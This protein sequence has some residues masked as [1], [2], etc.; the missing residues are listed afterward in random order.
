MSGRAQVSAMP[1]HPSP[2]LR[3]D[4]SFPARADSTS[5]MCNWLSIPPPQCRLLARRDAEDDAKSRNVRSTRSLLL[6]PE[7]WQETG[8]GSTAAWLHRHPYIGASQTG[9]SIERQFSSISLLTLGHSLGA[10]PAPCGTARLCFGF[11]ALRVS[12]FRKSL[13]NER[14]RFSEPSEKAPLGLGSGAHS[15]RC[16][17]ECPEGNPGKYNQGEKQWH[18][19]KARS[20]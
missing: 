13:C 4:G 19:M 3:G 18:S 17:Q 2:T 9:V 11:A 20:L 12:A 10:C 14:K 6:Q 7:T 1:E 5:G 8:Y 16:A 15:R